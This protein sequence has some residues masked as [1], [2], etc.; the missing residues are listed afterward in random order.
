VAC[1][2]EP[3]TLHGT[4]HTAGIRCN[5]EQSRCKQPHQVLASA[6]VQSAI[7]RE[8]K[9]RL[10][11][12]QRLWKE[13]SARINKVSAMRQGLAKIIEKVHISRY[14]ESPET[15]LCIAENACC[16]DYADTWLLK[17]VHSLSKSQRPDRS[18]TKYG[19]EDTFKYN[20]GVAW[21]SLLITRIHL[22]V[23]PESKIQWLPATLHNKGWIDHHQVGDQSFE[24]IPILDPVDVEG[25]Y[26]HIASLYHS[27]QWHVQ[28]H[29]WHYASFSYKEHSMEGRLVLRREV[30]ATEAVQIFC[31]SDSN[32][33]YSSHFSKYSRSFLLVAIV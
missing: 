33:R 23:A 8:W 9:H 6:C 19:W 7:W 28:S 21:V 13:G 29:G 10:G 26:G 25:A 12:I 18:S 17:R 30:S 11:K 14:F 20:T 22:W 31:W 4:R 1:N 3:H 32:N 16:I 27:L 5:D 2:E 24:A 15:N